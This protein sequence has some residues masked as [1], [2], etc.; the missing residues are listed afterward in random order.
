M[1][2][3]LIVMACFVAGCSFDPQYQAAIDKYTKAKCEEL[4]GMLL[5]RD[6]KTV[7]P[8]TDAYF[9]F[10]CVTGKG[11][12]FFTTSVKEIPVQ[13]WSEKK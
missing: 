8:T 9:S 11:V 7:I 5:H 1:K 3:I 6:T 13:Y 2:K 4:G 12:E 10:E